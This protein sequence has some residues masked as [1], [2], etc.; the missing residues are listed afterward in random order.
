[1]LKGKPG[2][3]ISLGRPECRWEGNIKMDLKEEGWKDM[4]WLRMTQEWETVRALE[5]GNEILGYIKWGR[6]LAQL[7]GI[8][9]EGLW[10]IGACEKL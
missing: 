6:F 3:N 5:H 7:K 9:S 4:D 10:F 8:D 2:E 1:M